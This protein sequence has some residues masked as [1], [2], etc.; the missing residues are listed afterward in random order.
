MQ[1]YWFYWRRGWWAMFMIACMNIGAILIF[2]PLAII[3]SERPGA[4]VFSFLVAY[5]AIASPWCGWVFQ[6][7]SEKAHASDARLRQKTG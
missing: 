1:S 4:Y 7:F 6:R 2:L 3:F 5:L